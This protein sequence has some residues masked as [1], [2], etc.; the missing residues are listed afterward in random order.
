MLFC[1]HFPI[2]LLW[3]FRVESHEPEYSLHIWND[4]L[5][6]IKKKYIKKNCNSTW[7]RESN[8]L[9]SLLLV[10]WSCFY[11]SVVSLLLSLS[12]FLITSP[13][14]WGLLCYMCRPLQ[15]KR[16]KRSHEESGRIWA[17]S[18]AAEK[19]YWCICSFF[20]LKFY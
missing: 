6:K 5:W 14:M 20:C 8:T 18:T 3:E 7:P 2:K 16:K 10:L 11:W 9:Y 19:S 13:H 17:K 15:S 12:I 1:Y 4:V